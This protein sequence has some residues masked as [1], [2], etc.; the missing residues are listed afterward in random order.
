MPQ[1]GSIYASRV[2]RD[3]STCL[4]NLKHSKGVGA[5]PKGP[6]AKRNR[7]GNSLADHTTVDDQR[8]AGDIAG[9]GTCQKQDGCSD[10]FWL[11]DPI[12]RDPFA[13]FVHDHVAQLL[14]HI[15]FDETRG[16][17][18][19]RYTAVAQFFRHRASHPDHARFDAE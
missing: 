1:K 3:D 8:L 15:A 14:G 13:D 2:I 12:G 18:V 7:G 9:G 16:N 6:A 11:P 5:T 17:G 10:V 19:D 4:R